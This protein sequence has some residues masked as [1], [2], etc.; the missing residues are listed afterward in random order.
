MERIS[1]WKE[2]QNET[3]IKSEQISIETNIKSERISVRMKFYRNEFLSEQ[4]SE[5]SQ[6]LNSIGTKFQNGMN[7][8]WN[9]Y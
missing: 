3:N 7:F 2:V 6:R 1:E 5:K 9:K 8:Y 4:I